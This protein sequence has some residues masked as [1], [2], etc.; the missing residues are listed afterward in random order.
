MTGVQTCALPIWLLQSDL[1]YGRIYETLG[2]VTKIRVLGRQYHDPEPR[3]PLGE[4]IRLA[5]E[6][7]NEVDK[8]AIAVYRGN[9]KIGY[10]PRERTSVIREA[11]K[12]IERGANTELVNSPD[13]LYLINL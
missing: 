9:T 1:G 4:D 8:N 2:E 13:S 5:P 3:Q 11:Q 7:T 6:P 10:V 12:A